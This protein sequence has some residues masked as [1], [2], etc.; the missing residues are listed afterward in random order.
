M[1]SYL[2]YNERLS[3][4]IVQT[5]VINLLSDY[6]RAYPEVTFKLVIF[7]NIYFWLTEWKF[8]KQLVA[9]AQKAG[10]QINVFPLA[11]PTRGWLI[12]S[13]GIR[14]HRILFKITS[15]VIPDGTVVCR[16]YLSTYLCT[17][18]VLKQRFNV[19]AD[20]RSLYVRENIGTRWNEGDKKYHLWLD[21]EKAIAQHASKLIV[22]NQSMLKYFSQL[23][24][25]SRERIS[26]I[27]IYTRAA[28]RTLATSKQH[29]RVR[30]IYVGSLSLSK[31]NDINA[32][33]KFFYA[34]N[35]EANRIELVLII[36]HDGPLIKEL[37]SEL[38]QMQYPFSL[39]IALNPMEVRAELSEADI[40][41][42]ITDAWEDA[43]ARTGVKTI[44]YLASNLIVWTTKYFSDVAQIVGDTDTGFVFDRSDPVPAQLSYALDDFLRRRQQL[45]S[46]AKALY[47][48]SYSSEAILA[49]L[50]SVVDPYASSKT[51]VNAFKST[52]KYD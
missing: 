46:Q 14:L 39:Y 5:Q 34:L 16:G 48:T 37:R 12:G 30:L 20:P 52:S 26:I 40:G 33:R 49:E 28:N 21:I 35:H 4:P 22:V 27:P 47:E 19:I 29:G 18:V 51:M 38:K 44:E 7:Q 23:P 24:E 1:I 13:F 36:K 10:L 45:L 50:R 9:D 41:L 17:N 31:W 11:L 25:M 42:A 8:R 32:Y 15:L 2:L 43:G 3:E 6:N